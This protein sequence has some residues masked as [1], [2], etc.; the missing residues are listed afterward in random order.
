MSEKFPR[1]GRTF[2]SSKSKMFGLFIVLKRLKTVTFDTGYTAWTFL[3]SFGRLII[4]TIPLETGGS[5][6]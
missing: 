4:G 1:G 3:I 6:M 2:F 5:V